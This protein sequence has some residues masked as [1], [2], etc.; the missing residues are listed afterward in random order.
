MDI[1]NHK[2]VLDLVGALVLPSGK[3]SV[4]VLLVFVISKK[5]NLINLIIF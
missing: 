4:Q 1:D 5:M 3:V 2:L